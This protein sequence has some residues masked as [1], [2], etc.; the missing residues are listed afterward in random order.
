MMNKTY[1]IRE[2]MKN[3]KNYFEGQMVLQGFYN[4]KAAVYVSAG[5][6]EQDMEQQIMVHSAAPGNR[7]L[8]I[9]EATQLVEMCDAKGIV[10]IAK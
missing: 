9:F 2:T 8:G 7:F 1:V 3:A 5:Y 4:G 10:L 6:S